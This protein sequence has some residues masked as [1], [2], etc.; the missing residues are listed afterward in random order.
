MEKTLAT[1]RPHSSPANRSVSHDEV[2]EKATVKGA[3]RAKL[4]VQSSKAPLQ[5]SERS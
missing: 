3:V 4:D 5:S 1:V 2:D